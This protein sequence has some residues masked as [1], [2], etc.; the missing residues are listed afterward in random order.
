VQTPAV[1]NLATGLDETLRVER[2]TSS[3]PFGVGICAGHHEHV[4]DL[5]CFARSRLGV[6]QDNTLKVRVAFERF[7]PGPCHE[8]NLRARFNSGNQVSRHGLSEA[9]APHHE[10][11]M[12][13]SSGKENRSLPRRISTAYDGDL[14]V[15]ADCGLDVGSAV[16]DPNPFELGKVRQIQSAISTASGYDDRSTPRCS[17]IL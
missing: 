6:V 3:K 9:W 15:A 13:D 2:E 1:L 11:N 8:R 7:D 17:S 4:L 5:P 14:L 16:V 10:I 12:F